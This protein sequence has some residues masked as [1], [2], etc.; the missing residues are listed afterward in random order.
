[1]LGWGWSWES[2]RMV[3]DWLIDL[4]IDHRGEGAGR[5]I[6]LHHKPLHT[7]PGLQRVWCRIIYSLCPKK[8]HDPDR[9]FDGLICPGGQESIQ[10]LPVNPVIFC[11][12][13]P[14]HPPCIPCVLGWDGNMVIT[15]C[16]HTHCNT[17]LKPL[18]KNASVNTNLWGSHDV[19]R[20]I[21]FIYEGIKI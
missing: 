12:C 14:P 20:C 6:F 21:S 4:L 15:I 1:M 2:S 16:F 3:G 9:W 7:L 11:H 10:P 18:V 8:I 19:P 13:P 5:C 17:V